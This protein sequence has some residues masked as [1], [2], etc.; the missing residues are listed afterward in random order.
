MGIND[1]V[2]FATELF[3]GDMA[4]FNAACK[5][6]EA[7]ANEQEAQQLLIESAEEG[8]D[9]EAETG[10]APDFATLVSRLFL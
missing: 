7:S 9:W 4:G 1:R 8:I 6:I 5:A 2:R 3:D 10:A